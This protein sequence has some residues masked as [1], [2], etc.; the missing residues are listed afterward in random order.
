MIT[1]LLSTT[2]LASP[3]LDYSLRDWRAPS[4]FYRT[5]T[6]IRRGTTT[7][8][9]ENE[10]Q[11]P[12]TCL[13]RDTSPE[14]QELYR[15]LEEQECEGTERLAIGWTRTN[16]DDDDDTNNT[17]KLRGLFATDD[18]E[19]GEFIL[20]IP[21]PATLLVQE[22]IIDP[23]DDGNDNNHDDDNVDKEEEFTGDEEIQ[24]AVAFLE[25]FV[26]EPTWEPYIHCLPRV[27]QTSFDATPDFWTKQAL[28][29]FPVPLLRQRSQ[30]RYQRIQRESSSGK[31]KWSTQELQW[32]VW[33][34]RS[35]GFTSLKQLSEGKLRER[36][37]LLPLIDMI[38]HEGDN[39]NASIEVI[40]TDSY[41]ESFIALQALCPIAQGEQ[42]TLRYGTGFET[43]LELL[44]KYGFY[45]R[46]NPNDERIDWDLVDLKM[47]EEQ[48]GGEVAPELASI[49]Q[50]CKHLRQ[51]RPT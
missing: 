27:D 45:T 21:L 16:D 30:E 22:K 50:F 15:F 36:T 29:R 4:W 3:R 40:E 51:K 9:L 2:L 31:T 14:V 18:F 1:S 32:A 13:E 20:A 26:T 24:Q 39:P 10:E 6:T 38:N 44:D 23:N 41:D 19:T 49:Y 35:R 8:S 7:Q 34:I 17:N 42:I 5:T 37:M 11:Y 48:G 43:S 47:L 46:E 25:K 33:I 28:E 12:T